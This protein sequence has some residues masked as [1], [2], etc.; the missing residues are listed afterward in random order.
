MNLLEYCAQVDLDFDTLKFLI[1]LQYIDNTTKIF[2]TFPKLNNGACLC[3]HWLVTQYGTIRTWIL[4]NHNYLFMCEPNH[5][6]C[7]TCF[8]LGSHAS[9]PLIKLTLRDQ[10]FCTIFR[11]AQYYWPCRDIIEE[12][13][14]ILKT[15]K[16]VWYFIAQCQYIE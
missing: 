3:V 15:S 8:G 12:W 5:V 10:C 16:I 9:L 11:I 14:N 13:C 1:L 7:Y 2:I 4:T 6:C